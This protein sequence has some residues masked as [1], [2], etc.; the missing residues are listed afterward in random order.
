MKFDKAMIDLVK[1]IRRRS[2]SEL[3][4]G[5]KLANPELLSELLEQFHASKDVVTK[6]LIKELFS[7][8]GDPWPD[9]L[10]RDDKPEKHY[11]TMVYRGQVRHVETRSEKPVSDKVT[12]LMYRGQPVLAS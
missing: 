11:S 4:P 1:E 7:L 6:A 5:I 12:Q 8:A 2:P 10:K 9:A 3:K